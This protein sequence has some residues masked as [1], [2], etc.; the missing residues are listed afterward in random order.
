[1]T[2]RGNI[3]SFGETGAVPSAAEVADRLS[4][5]EVLAMHSRGVD[6]ADP[7]ILK[8]AYW[9][10]AEVAYGGYNG[11]A[12]TFCEILPTSIQRYA[13]TAHKISNLCIAFRGAEARVETYVTAY[14]YLKSDAEGGAEVDTEMTYIGR[15]LDT[16]EKRDNVWKIRFRRVVMDWNQNANATAILEGPP[17]EGL[18]RGARWPDDPLY[19]LLS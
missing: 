8:S 1:M 13:G 19:E 4:I 10:D 14:H 12:H 7:V 11:S 3:F 9:P 6:R 5:A 15:Y 16:M 18:A 2:E 17:F